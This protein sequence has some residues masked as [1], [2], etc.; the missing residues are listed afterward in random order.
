M[1]HIGEAQKEMAAPCAC[2]CGCTYTIIGVSKRC[3][4]CSL[5]EHGSHVT[6]K[7][8]LRD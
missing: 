8:Q 7:E 3:E 4:V 6:D 1:D 5:C 2:N